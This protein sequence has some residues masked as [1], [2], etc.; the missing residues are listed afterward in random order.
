MP[1]SS[2]R[3]HLRGAAPL[4]KAE[5][6]ALT[7]SV[8]E[9]ATIGRNLDQ[10]AR[11]LNQ[12]GSGAVARPAR[13]RRH[14]EGRGRAPGSFQ[15]IAP[16]QCAIL[17]SRGC[18]VSIAVGIGWRRRGAIRLR[19]PSYGTHLALQRLDHRVDS[20]FFRQ[21]LPSLALIGGLH[22]DFLAWEGRREEQHESATATTFLS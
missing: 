18:G 8:A 22:Y 4:P 9:L 5:Y 10:I 13:G 6:L 7:Q 16:C 17:D 12:G 2:Y 14:A 19:L 1:R 15:G 3:S 11:V 21:A 20:V